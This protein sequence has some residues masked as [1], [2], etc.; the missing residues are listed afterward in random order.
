MRRAVSAGGLIVMISVLAASS[1]GSAVRTTREDYLPDATGSKIVTVSP[2]GEA[3]SGLV[4]MTQALVTKEAGPRRA[5]RA[6]GETY[7]FLPSTLVVRAEE[8]TRLT[9]WN[10]QNDDVHDFML[11]DA[12]GDVLMKVTLPPLRRTSWVFTFHQAGLLHFYCTM[13]QPEMSG[14]VIVLPSVPGSSGTGAWAR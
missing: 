6:F 7:A 11:T 14:E 2:S 13:H 10:L 8:P 1:T 5:L 12:E 9:F 3:R 4:V